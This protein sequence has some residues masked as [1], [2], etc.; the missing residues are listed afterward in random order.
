MSNLCLV[1]TSPDVNKNKTVVFSVA[2]SDISQAVKSSG[3][4]Q[5]HLFS[6]SKLHCVHQWSRTGI[7]RI[8]S[9]W[10]WKKYILLVPKPNVSVSTHFASTLWL[11]RKKHRKK[12]K[13][14]IDMPVCHTKESKPEN[15][16]Q[17]LTLTWFEYH[18]KFSW[19]E[20]ASFVL[21]SASRLCLCPPYTAYLEVL[22][23]Y[24]WYYLGCV[25]ILFLG[26]R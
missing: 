16:W 1:V 8:K 4:S 13:T 3:I 21:V 5:Q 24:W 17:I 25:L 23:Q 7:N 6:S 20:V 15:R 12:Y 18:K 9:L 10:T 14:P 19:S 22:V 11:P 2:S 26:T